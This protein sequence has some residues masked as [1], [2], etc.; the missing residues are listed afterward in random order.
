M[1]GATKFYQNA[2]A[3]VKISI[4]AP[5]SGAT[6]REKSLGLNI[7]ISIHAPMSGATRDYFHCFDNISISIHAPMSGA[8]VADT[9]VVTGITDFNP[10]SHV[11][12]DKKEMQ[13]ND[14]STK[15]QSTLPCRERPV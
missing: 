14:Q 12:S 9:A 8:T 7:I 2:S 5:M 3:S 4:H 13:H 10:R 15:F 1:S 6:L 11:G